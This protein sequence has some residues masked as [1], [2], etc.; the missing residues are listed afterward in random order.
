MKVRRASWLLLSI[1][2]VTFGCGKGD[3]GPTGPAGPAGSANVIYG[4]WVSV[5]A[6]TGPTV[7]AT[8]HE[9]SYNLT[10]AALTQAILDNGVVLVYMKQ[11]T[12]PGEVAQLPINWPINGFTFMFRSTVGNIK[13]VYHSTAS[14]TTD[15]AV[16][17]AN[18]VSLRY[19]L[20]PGGVLGTR[21]QEVGSTSARYV[22]QLKAMSY[23]EACRTLGIPE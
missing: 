23:P 4:A 14:P 18:W 2:L 22:E 19:I 5:A 13:V 16:Y 8:I 3:T 17:V 15:P 9:M 7:V 6:W 10:P 1:A 11:N 20:I 21:A 12:L